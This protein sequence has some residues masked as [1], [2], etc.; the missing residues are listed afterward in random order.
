M[1]VI[2]NIENKVVMLQKL[3]CN[4]S[5]YMYRKLQ[6]KNVGIIDT[7]YSLLRYLGKETTYRTI[8]INR[9]GY[10]T[11]TRE[12]NTTTTL[13]RFILEYY[14][15]Y[16]EH[17]KQILN[18]AD[19]EINHKNRNKLD[20]RIENLEIVTHSDNV[21]HVYGTS[22][23]V[24]YSTE[25]LKQLQEQNLQQKQQVIDEKYLKRMSCL[26]YKFMKNNTLDIAL[27]KCCYFKFRV[28][29]SRSKQNTS[30]SIEINKKKELKI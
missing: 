28:I 29:K 30:N 3:I 17:L 10:P 14:S 1:I 22:Y 4:G 16:D 8:N 25:Q 27:L 13:G 11:I 23:N 9:S 18:N 5:K 2:T 21:K 26:F 6:E 15:R 20:N 24:A 7:D 12:D 19:F